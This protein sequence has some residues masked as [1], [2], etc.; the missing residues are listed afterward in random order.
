MRRLRKRREARR[1]IRRRGVQ[2]PRTKLLRRKV[3]KR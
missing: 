2:V 1:K 3:K